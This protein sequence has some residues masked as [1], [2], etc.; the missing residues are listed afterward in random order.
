MFMIRIPPNGKPGGMH[1]GN[2]AGRQDSTQNCKH[3]C[4]DPMGA[5]PND[6]ISTSRRKAP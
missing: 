5:G 4:T 3:D 6:F 1:G 2:P